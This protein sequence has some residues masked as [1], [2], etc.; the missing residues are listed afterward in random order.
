MVSGEVQTILSLYS[1]LYFLCGGRKAADKGSCD[2]LS[3]H[4]ASILAHLDVAKTN[5]VLNLSRQMGVTPSTMSLNIA[6]L[7]KRGYV[8]RQINPQDARQVDLRLTRR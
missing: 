3:V 8:L 2:V 6:R 7:V 1:R 4:Q 5:T